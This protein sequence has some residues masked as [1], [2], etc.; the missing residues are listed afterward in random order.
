MVVRAC[1]V[2]ECHDALWAACELE[3][4]QD[5]APSNVECEVDAGRR[6]RSNAVGKT[7]AVGDW[8]GSQ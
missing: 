5:A 6:E 2:G 4:G 8:L 1:E 7:L 3:L